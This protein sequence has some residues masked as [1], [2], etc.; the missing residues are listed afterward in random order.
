MTNTK[1]NIYLDFIEGFDTDSTVSKGSMFG[2]PCLKVHNKVFAVEF[3]AGVVFKLADDAR[4]TALELPGAQLWAP[5][6]K[7][8]VKKEWVYLP[9]VS[10]EDLGRFSK[11]SI[12][13]VSHL[14]QS[15]K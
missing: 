8:H 13:Y 12:D 10:E 15:N 6:S 1:R 9:D 2:M 7:T 14:A 11:A 3:E 4:R 5:F